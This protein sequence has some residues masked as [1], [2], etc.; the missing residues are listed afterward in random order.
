M[1]RVVEKI[2][3]ITSFTTTT[4]TTSTTTSF[5]TL[6]AGTSSVT[7]ITAITVTVGNLLSRDASGHYRSSPPSLLLVEVRRL[8]PAARARQKP[9]EAATSRPHTRFGRGQFAEPPTRSITVLNKQCFQVMS[10]PRRQEACD[11]RPA[12]SPPPCTTTSLKR[13]GPEYHLALP[14]AGREIAGAGRRPSSAIMHG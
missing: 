7:E 13:P 2:F 4:T 8:L 9:G 5:L 11:P 10:A 3:C 14:E 1:A 12:G 6:Q